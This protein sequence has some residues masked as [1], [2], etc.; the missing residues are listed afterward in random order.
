MKELFEWLAKTPIASYSI[1]ICFALISISVVLIYVV[2][3]FQGRQI[4][5]WPPKIGEKPRNKKPAKHEADLSSK[6]NGISE[7]EILSFSKFLISDIEMPQS[8]KE[9][10]EEYIRISISGL[11]RIKVDGEYL[12]VKGKR[13]NQYQPVGG[14]FKRYKASQYLF[15]KLGILDDNKMPIDS[16]SKDD[17]RIRVRINSLDQFLGWYKT[18]KNR[19][20]SPWREFYEELV[21]E[22]LLAKDLFP[23]IDYEHIRTHVSGIKFTKH[24]HPNISPD[25]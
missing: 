12:L 22:G 8:I 18:G 23:Y 15:E 5:F 17:L 3:F 7:G 19:E 25:F 20:T 4:E 11:F 6:L 14:V 21:T 2:S 9:K 10:E 24:F 16:K 1:A 13:I